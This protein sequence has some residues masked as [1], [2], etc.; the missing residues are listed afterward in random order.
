M[1]PTRSRTVPRHGVM[2]SLVIGTVTAISLGPRADTET[3]TS[4]APPHCCSTPA[5]TTADPVI[6]GRSSV[7]DRHFE[8]AGDLSCTADD[9]GQP[10]QAGEHDRDQKHAEEDENSEARSEKGGHGTLAMVLGHRPGTPYT[11]PVRSRITL[12]F[13]RAKTLLLMS[14]LILIGVVGLVAL[15]R[16][17]DP[18]EVAG[19]L[20]FVPVFAGFLFFGIPGGVT[21]GIAAG[22]A[23]VVL[24]WPAVQLVGLSPLPGQIV[25]RVAGYIIFGMGGGWAI[26]Q[27]QAT[28]EKL[29]LHDDI[30][31][32]TG[33]G[34]ARSMLETV[35]LE[36]ARADRYQKLFSVVAAD[37]RAPGW[38]E[39]SPRKQRTVLRDLGIKVAAGVRATDHVGPRPTRRAPHH[40]G[41]AAGDRRSRGQDLCRESPSPADR[42]DDVRRRSGWRP[43]PTLRDPEPLTLILDLFKELDR[44][45]R[46][47]TV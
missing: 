46:P 29:E 34:N 47:A 43:R 7:P 32:E 25:A 33:L 3:S 27:I 13:D 42:F 40:R 44:S 18:V 28:L 8:G 26:G 41:G 4:R 30:D 15:T 24:R 6:T 22:V 17:V 20:L 21:L 1:L 14:G 23:Y 38:E 39:L 35:D 37:F 19:T 16:G 31:D 12:T 36:R 2:P 10:P 5:S 45:Q 11:A 9:V